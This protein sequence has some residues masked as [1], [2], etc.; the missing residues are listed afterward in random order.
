MLFIVCSSLVFTY[1]FSQSA[2]K[3]ST[4]ELLTIYGNGLR[5]RL[6]SA[7]YATGLRSRPIVTGCAQDLRSRSALTI[8]GHAHGLRSLRSRSMVTDCAHG[9]RSR[10]AVTIHC[11]S[12]RYESALT[13]Y[14]MVTVCAHDHDL[15]TL[16][17]CGHST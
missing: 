8:Y 4:H 13:I 2:L 9:L 6:A 5:S 1:H 11:H 10:S 16:T 7:I 3:S 12:L 14:A 15:R 17:V